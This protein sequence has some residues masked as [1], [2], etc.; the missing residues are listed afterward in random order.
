[1]LRNILSKEELYNQALALKKKRLKPGYDGMSIEGAASWIFI[2]G[3]RLCKDILRGDYRPMPAMGFRT[4]KTS[5]GYRQLVR[6]SAIDVVLQTWL[7]SVLEPT[8][9][10]TF[11]DNSMAYRQGR[12]VHTAL[13][14]YVLLS[15]QKKHVAKLDVSA[16]FNNIDHL[17]LENKLTE[18]LQ[19]EE[20]VRL[21]MSFVKLPLSI[22]GTLEAP[23]KG[24]FQGMPLAPL[25][26]NIY[27]HSVDEFLQRKGVDFIRYADDIVL[28][29]DTYVEASELLKM[30]S[31]LI[32]NE[33]HLT[34]NPKKCRVGSPTSIKYLGHSFTVDKKGTMAYNSGSETR[35]AYYNWHS[36]RPRNSRG[37]IEI[38]S[39]GIL[40]QKDYSLFFDTE[41]VDSAIPI[42]GIDT[43]NIHSNVI[44]DAGFLSLAMKNNIAVNVFDQC[45]ELLGTFAPNVALKAPRLTHEQ[46]LAYYDREHRMAIAKEFV[47]ASIHN[48]MLNIRYH[49]KFYGDPKYASALRS[50]TALKSNVKKE[51]DYDKLLLLEAHARKIY[52]E[53]YDL[54]IRR[55][56]FSFGCRSKKPP[57][58]MVNAMISFGNSVMY[59]LVATEIQKTALDVRIG[60]LHATNKRKNSLNLDIAEIFKPLLV[61]RVILSLINKGEISP[62]HFE[63]FANDGVYLTTEGKKI[64]L[65]AFYEKLDTVI[66]VGD[67]KMSYDSVIKEE[68]RSLIRHFRD[69]SEYKGF[70][71]VR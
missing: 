48:D 24:I 6:L 62:I 28:F 36:E 58:N 55:E 14:R 13:E 46:L 31:D 56:G 15:N 40:K 47:L 69:R 66:T 32:E 71:Q 67:K 10:E 61:D 50:L 30:T 3:D 54:F 51:E 7:D 34:C 59:S 70:R 60:Y 4:A 19:D 39:D 49:N 8:F 52:Y 23:D 27:F 9:E 57:R 18:Y 29:A 53:C 25:L 43:I 68:I 42:V 38:L 5:G 11:S 22:D 64:F 65:S 35:A 17:I 16:C 26:C 12:G 21:I 20:M 44:F 37:N 41:T 45:G 2:N 33:L 63:A 1:M